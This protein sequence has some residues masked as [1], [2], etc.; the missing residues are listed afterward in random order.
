MD[1]PQTVRDY[2]CYVLS[3]ERDMSMLYGSL[4]S[5]QKMVGCPYRIVVVS[6]GSI[7]C[8][9]KL[10]LERNFSCLTV[11]EWDAFTA[12]SEW[13]KRFEF[14][15]DTPMGRK[16]ILMTLMPLGGP[17]FYMDSDVVFFPGANDCLSPAWCRREPSVLLDCQYSLDMRMLDS[18][19]EVGFSTNA[20]FFIVP[21]KIPWDLFMDRIERVR[22]SFVPFSEQTV[23][24]L[25]L[26]AAGGIALDPNTCILEIEDSFSEDDLYATNS[27]AFRHYVAPFARSKIGR[28]VMAVEGGNPAREEFRSVIC[29][30]RSSELAVVFCRTLTRLR[31]LGYRELVEAFLK[32]FCIGRTQ[33]YWMMSG[34]VAGI[35]KAL[36][37]EQADCV[38]ELFDIE[39]LGIQVWAAAST[40][41]HLKSGIE[42][43]GIIPSLL[44]LNR[45]VGIAPIVHLWNETWGWVA[46]SGAKVQYKWV[47]IYPTVRGVAEW[48]F[49][50]D[51]VSLG[52][53]QNV[54]ALDRDWN[55]FSGGSP[56]T[57]SGRSL[58]RRLARC[59]ILH[60]VT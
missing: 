29:C 6:D 4:D 37:H 33:S 26:R 23:V 11:V 25:A 38:K 40:Q 53:D 56:F 58:R 39:M 59:G 24:H 52:S 14:L 20:G 16:L 21:N 55:W 32:R 47:V 51:P 42:D 30:R 2:A 18:P 10:L 46:V 50:E 27:S 49:D 41:P 34:F 1:L 15:A 44:K 17:S 12:E 54:E 5:L 28:S 31:E 19:S 8:K 35:A 7:S 13:R 36:E 9:S 43:G 48:Y 60:S 22:D 57:C 3:C 45:I